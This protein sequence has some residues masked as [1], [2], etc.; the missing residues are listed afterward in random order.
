LQNSKA[1]TFPAPTASTKLAKVAATEFSQ[2]AAN[3]NDDLSASD[4]IAA[5]QPKAEGAT[6]GRDQTMPTPLPTLPTIIAILPLPLIL[7]LAMLV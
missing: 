2:P 3:K 5:M 6:Q 4:R 7:L 1:H